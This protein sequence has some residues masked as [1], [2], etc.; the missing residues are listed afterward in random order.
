MFYKQTRLQF[1]SSCVSSFDSLVEFGVCKP[2]FRFA[3]LVCLL[4]SAPQE[5]ACA[6]QPVEEAEQLLIK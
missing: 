5:Q 3:E 1:S 4:G 6:E 2:S